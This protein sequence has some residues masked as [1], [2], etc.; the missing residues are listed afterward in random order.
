MLGGPLLGLPFCGNPCGFEVHSLV[1]GQLLEGLHSAGCRASR[2][3]K[4]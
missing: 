1:A 2:T 3:V 4:L